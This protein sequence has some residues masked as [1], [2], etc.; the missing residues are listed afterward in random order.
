M[1]AEQ[2]III[3]IL[4][5]AALFLFLPR[6]VVK[7][8]NNPFIDLI[9]T[10]CCLVIGF[11]LMM[12]NSTVVATIALNSSSPAVTAEVFRYTWMFGWAGYL[13]LAFTIIKT[14]WDIIAMYN[15]QKIS[16]RMGR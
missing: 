10:R 3:F 5:G 8:S 9:L 12:M 15:E 14:L 11:F 2:G 7:F 13:L 4:C 1:S 16:Q 6:I